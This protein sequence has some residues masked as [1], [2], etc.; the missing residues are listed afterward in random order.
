M[1]KTTSTYSLDIPTPSGLRCE[2]CTSLCTTS[3]VA[4]R[5]YF[6]AIPSPDT[7]MSRENRYAYV[8]ITPCCSACY[9]RGL[10]V[11]R[12]VTIARQH[13]RTKK[14]EELIAHE[15]TPWRLELGGYPQDLQTTNTFIEDLVLASAE[16]HCDEF[17]IDAFAL[18]VFRDSD[19]NRDDVQLIENKD[20]LWLGT[21]NSTLHVEE[22]FEC[23]A[24]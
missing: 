15:M 8:N 11:R 3:A 16:R 18:T 17:L 5:D 2:L 24:A 13:I 1:A 10:E 12:C 23:G 20:L 22:A 7:E 6:H 4:V 9:E 14:T 21:L 19:L